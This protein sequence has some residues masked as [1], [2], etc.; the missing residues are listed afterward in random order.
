MTSLTAESSSSP[1]SAASAPASLAAS[2][3]VP[4]STPASA[5]FADSG[6]DDLQ[7]RLRTQLNEVSQLAGGL[8]HEIRNPISTMLLTLDLLAEEFQ[9]PETP[10]DQ[11]VQ[12]R[13]ERVRRE[14]Q[15]LQQILEDFLRLA[16]LRNMNL[17]PSDLNSAID[18]VR[19]FYEPQ[20]A[21]HDVVLRVHYDET[22]S[23]TWLDVNLFKQALLNL[24]LNAQQA[25][26]QGGELI[27]TTRR[28][29]P[30]NVLDVV[31][32]GAGIAP[33]L[34]AKVFEPFYST[35]PG[36]N[37]LGLPM[38]RRIVECHGGSVQLQSELGKGS[39]FSLRLPQADEPRPSPL[40]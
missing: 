19:D 22:M 5:S 30:W 16:R 33:E 2:A 9:R 11:R 26:P 15:R 39:R 27:M 34:Q 18:D 31:D 38:V 7:A 32:T 4:V 21:M 20:A 29:G 40:T 28:D 24:L 36:G 25:M 1:A 14:A 13:I 12:K 17:E 35:K 6:T 23:R 37:G 10:R 3:P 8:A